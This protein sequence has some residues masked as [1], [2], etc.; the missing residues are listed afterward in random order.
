MVGVDSEGAGG[1]GGIISG[2]G[3]TEDCGGW[4][5]DGAFAGE[6]G[7]T[8]EWALEVEQ[9]SELSPGKLVR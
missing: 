9:S 4:D 1:E 3:E 5:V 8:G 2:A 6:I 7:E